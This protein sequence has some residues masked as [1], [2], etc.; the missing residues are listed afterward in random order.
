MNIR[1]ELHL[2]TQGNK[3]VR[4]HDCYTLT[5]D[6]RIKFCQFL[7]SMKFPNKYAS[8]TAKCVNVKEGSLSGLKSHDCHVLLEP[9]L[10]KGIQ[11]YLLK[12]LCTTIVELCN[13]FRQLCT[14]TIIVAD[15]DV[16]EKGIIMIH[17][18]LE[19]IFPTAFFY[20]MAHLVIHLPREAKYSGPV[21]FK[22]MYPIER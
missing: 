14:K 20:I 3:L 11:P 10:P 2:T 22:W 6:E 5:L 16:L 21:S 8:N 19:C 1:K 7:K 18:K 9:L 17:C 15:L 13:F 4:S 12:D